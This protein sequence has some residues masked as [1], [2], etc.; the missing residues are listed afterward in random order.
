MQNLICKLL[1]ESSMNKQYL[2]ILNEAFSNL[3]ILDVILSD[4]IKRINLNGYPNQIQT[5][6]TYFQL[7]TNND[8]HLYFEISPNEYKSKLK[9]FIFD[10]FYVL[11]LYPNEEKKRTFFV[12]TPSPNKIQNSEEMEYIN[13]IYRPLIGICINN[14]I[15]LLQEKR[16]TNSDEFD[17][18]LNSAFYKCLDYYNYALVGNVIRNKS[19]NNF[20]FTVPEI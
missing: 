10:G 13:T 17:E 19:N 14:F 18:L 20:S 5:V 3:T 7:N 16:E 8:A 2:N 6:K 15:L 1:D 4:Q 11:E 9:L 12:I